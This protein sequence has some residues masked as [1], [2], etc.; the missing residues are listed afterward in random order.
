M[1]TEERGVIMH[2]DV[3]KFAF[4]NMVS[5]HSIN[6]THEQHAINAVMHIFNVVSNRPGANNPKQILNINIFA[7]FLEITLETTNRLNP[8]RVGNSLNLF[9]KLLVN[10]YNFSNYLTPTNPGKL[11]VSI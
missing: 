2:T 4:K 10:N 11:F 3:I 5:R 9:S 6:L 7:D 8:Q 1:Y